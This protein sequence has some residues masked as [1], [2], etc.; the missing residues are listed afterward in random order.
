M[1]RAI[2][3]HIHYRYQTRR[4]PQKCVATTLEAGL[5]DAASRRPVLD[6]LNSPRLG[7]A[8]QR[9]SPRPVKFRGAA[10]ELLHVAASLQR[11]RYS[12]RVTQRHSNQQ[13]LKRIAIRRRFASEPTFDNG[14]PKRATDHSGGH[15]AADGGHI[16]WGLRT[17]GHGG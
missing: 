17:A 1:S 12:N 14:P 9:P 7:W 13:A 15:G 4:Q 3:G 6:W 11:V 8:T 2:S 5:G 16:I 10:P